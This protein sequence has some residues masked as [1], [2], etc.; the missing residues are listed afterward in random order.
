MTRAASDLYDQMVTVIKMAVTARNIY[1]VPEAAEKAAMLGGETHKGL[2]QRWDYSFTDESGHT[3]NVR[4]RWYD[5]SKPFSIQPDMHKMSVE[6]SGPAPKRYE[7]S[8]EE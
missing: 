6:L 3:V 5:Q 8:Y 2:S 4:C 1:A 7:G